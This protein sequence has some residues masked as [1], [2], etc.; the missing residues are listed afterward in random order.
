MGSGQRLCECL[1]GCLEAESLSRTAVELGGDGV[2]RGLVELAQVAALG[3]VLAEQAVG[4]LV[5]ATLPGLRGSQ[6]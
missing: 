2:Q 6:K 5:G 1:G 3:E 4:V